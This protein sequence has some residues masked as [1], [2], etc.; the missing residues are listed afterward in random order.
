MIRRNSAIEKRS[1]STSL[2][3][4]NAASNS[5]LLPTSSLMTAPANTPVV[6]SHLSHLNTTTTITSDDQSISP[7]LSSSTTTSPMTPMTPISPHIPSGY[8]TSDISNHSQL[9]HKNTLSSS[10]SL[11]CPQHQNQISSIHHP[12][13]QH[14]HAHHHNVLATV[15]AV[16]PRSSPK[17]F[18]P[19]TDGLP[20]LP[21]KPSLSGNMSNNPGT[22]F[23]TKVK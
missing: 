10:T 6:V 7:A 12:Q 23:Y 17:E 19:K 18:S 9:F 5:I 22:F 20:K 4:V 13:F 21:P 11:S 1:A 3:S 16:H 14:P 8:Q 15:A 2:G